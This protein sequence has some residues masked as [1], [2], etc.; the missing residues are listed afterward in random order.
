MNAKGRRWIWAVVLL[1]LSCCPLWI[2]V[3]WAYER[4]EIARLDRV[5]DDSEIPG[6]VAAKDARNDWPMG[7]SNGAYVRVHWLVVT[8]DAQRL[9]DFVDGLDLPEGVEAGL[10]DLGL[11]PGMMGREYSGVPHE[12]R[13]FLLTVDSGRGPLWWEPPD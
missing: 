3:T 11:A 2:A 13:L 6:Y 7:N 1:A 12:A 5:V 9:T 4:F 8:E 10:Y